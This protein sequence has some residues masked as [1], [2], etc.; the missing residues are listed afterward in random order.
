MPWCSCTPDKCSSPHT[1]NTISPLPYRWPCCMCRFHNCNSH[2]K[3]SMVSPSGPH[4]T[5]EDAKFN[6]IHR[7][8][9]ALWHQQTLQKKKTETPKKN[10]EFQPLRKTMWGET[11]THENRKNLVNLLCKKVQWNYIMTSMEPL[12]MQT[13]LSR[14]WSWMPMTTGNTIEHGSIKPVFAVGTQ[15]TSAIIDKKISGKRCIHW[16]WNSMK[17]SWSEHRQTWTAKGI[18]ATSVIR[19]RSSHV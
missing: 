5:K 19:S 2:H 14:I 10:Q 8:K 15:T 9:Q 16:R 18:H 3:S 7:C 12:L 13:A 6:A 11:I 1:C 17:G 4:C